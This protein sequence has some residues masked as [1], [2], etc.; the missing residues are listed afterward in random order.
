MGQV[1]P[2]PVRLTLRPGDIRAEHVGQRVAVE[3]IVTRASEVRPEVRVAA[4]ECLSCGEVVLQPQER[5]EEMLRPPSICS[6]PNCGGRYLKERV[7]LHQYGNWQGLQVQERPEAL[8]GGRMP[9]RL[10]AVARDGLVNRCWPGDHV[11]LEGTLRARRRGKGEKVLIPFLEVEGVE[12]LDKR[13]EEVELTEEELGEVERLRRDPQLF[14]KMVESVAPAVEGLRHVKEAILLQLFGAD[15]REL[16]DGTRLRGEIHILLTGDPGVAKSQILHWVATVAPRG[17]Y[18][19]GRK[20]TAAGLTATAVRDEL[21]G[22]WTL[23]AGAMVLA[24]GGICCVDELERM[25]AEDRSAM[26][27]ALEHCKVTVAKAGIVATLNARTSVLAASNPKAGRF[28]RQRLLHEQVGLDP[29]LLSRFDLIFVVRDEPGEERDGRIADRVLRVRERGVVPPLTPDQL[30]NLL[31]VAKREVH[32]VLTPGLAEKI[33][34]Y[35][36]RWRGQ[37]EGGVPP[38]TVRQLEGV[39]RLALASARARFSQVVE[40]EDV[41]RAVRLVSYYLQEVGVDP[42]TGKPDIDTVLTGVPMSQRRKIEMAEEIFERLEGK[43]GPSV[44]EE[45]LL[46]EA[47]KE[48]LGRAWM[49]RYLEEEVM[50]GAVYR[51][52]QGYVCRVVR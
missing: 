39:V 7:D 44:P 45:A 30:R 40:E 36:V 19:S 2:R 18:A 25:A 51:P 49:E 1:T 29:A 14:E 23:E 38:V 42:A 31:V 26:L 41:Q 24:D 35:Y 3:G 27:E 21:S 32:P 4:Y 43:Y 28:D 6:N 9:R 20:A 16:P 47:E 50:R 46:E 12:V 22:T 52:R 48:G 11:I 8:R 17:M 15:T 37:G 13:V 5:G 34:E 33:K 10:D